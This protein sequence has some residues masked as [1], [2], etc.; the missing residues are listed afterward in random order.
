MIRPSSTH[1]VAQ[2]SVEGSKSASSQEVPTSKVPLKLDEAVLILG[3]DE[4][5]SQLAWCDLLKS[6]DIEGRT[7]GVSSTNVFPCFGRD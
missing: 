6:D 4:V 2:P 3:T 7:V 5:P 1:H